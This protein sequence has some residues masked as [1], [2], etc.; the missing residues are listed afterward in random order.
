M[1]LSCQVTNEIAS[2]CGNMSPRNTIALNSS[3]N[4]GPSEGEGFSFN[5]ILIAHVL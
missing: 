3:K 2:C 4:K 5:S 1:L